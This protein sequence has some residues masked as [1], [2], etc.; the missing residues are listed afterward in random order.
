MIRCPKCNTLN[1]DSSR[2]CSECGAPLHKTRIRC[3]QCGTLNPVGNIFCDHCHVRLLPAEDADS[4]LRETKPS[5]ET[6]PRVQGISLPTRPSPASED[7]NADEQA[8]LPD[9][10]MGFLSPEGAEP[11]ATAEAAA[12]LGNLSA[13]DEEEGEL[14]APSELP[15]WLSGLGAE[16]EVVSAAP[17]AELEPAEGLPDWLS[18]LGAEEE[19]FSA[20]PEAELEPAED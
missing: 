17:E 7:G 3:P 8:E 11:E 4:A 1:R 19:A 18:G 10:L 20:A 12:S 14:L 13:P 2:F 15:D 6:L 5:E 9:W 16:E